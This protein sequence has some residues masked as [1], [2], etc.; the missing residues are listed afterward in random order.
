MSHRLIQASADRADEVVDAF[1]DAFHDYPVMRYAVGDAGADYER[2]LRMLIGVFVARRFDHGHPVL[3]IEESGQIMGVATLTLPGEPGPPSAAFDARR[4]A[5]WLDLGQE[6]KG[7]MEALVAVWQ[8]LSVP[9]PQYHLNMLGVRRARA[10]QGLGRILLDEVHRISREDPESTG[11]SLSTENPKNVLLYEHCGYEVRFH[12]RVS[13][14]LETW[15]LFRP[16]DSSGQRAG[17]P[18]R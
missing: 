7:R 11:V 5:L 4:E 17:T 16:D 15:I 18:E 1:V 6:A 14:E 12:E 3:A 10:G 13:P 2:R 9:G 8:R